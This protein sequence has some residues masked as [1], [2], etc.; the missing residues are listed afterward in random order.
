VAASLPPTQRAVARASI[1]A[2]HVAAEVPPTARELLS[3]ALVDLMSVDDVESRDGVLGSVAQAQIALGATAEAIVNARL[4][5]DP[6]RRAPVFAAI[7][8]AQV[9]AKERKQGLEFLSD[10]HKAA[11]EARNGDPRLEALGLVAVAYAEAG[12]F[13]HALEIVD[14]MPR[15][16]GD[17]YHVVIALAEIAIAQA[18]AGQSPGETFARAS[19]LLA[20]E[21][22]EFAKRHGEAVLA[23]ARAKAGFYED[24]VWAAMALVA[25]RGDVL[26]QVA[27]AM[28]ERGDRR[29][30]K[31]LLVPSSYYRDAVY[32][33]CGM[34][35]RIYPDCAAAI[36]EK[37]LRENWHSARAGH[38]GRNPPFEPGEERL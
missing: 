22:H 21:T 8:L 7:G 32:Q 31:M 12:E 29:F 36:A 19:M 14:E 18:G 15:G 35:G 4:I 3:L 10:A 17:S 13:G 27:K 38:A 20:G 30:F 37:M 2:R 1:A 16:Y 23:V 25:H 9:R 24:A 34:L 26:P 28:V 5:T 6:E 33:L 11:Q